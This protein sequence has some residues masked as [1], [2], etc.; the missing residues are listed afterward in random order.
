MSWFWRL[1]RQIAQRT[2]AVYVPGAILA[3]SALRPPQRQTIET[4]ARDAL[5]GRPV[6]QQRWH[7]AIPNVWA[8]NRWTSRF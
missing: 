1:R 2:A 4:A 6:A 3:V 5:N 8:E 7:C